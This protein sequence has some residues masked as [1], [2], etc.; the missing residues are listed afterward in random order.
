MSYP[1]GSAHGYNEGCRCTRCREANTKRARAR[2]EHV[3]TLRELINGRW[4]S[5]YTT[6][7]TLNGYGNWQCR[8][9]ACCDV[10]SKNLKRLRDER[11]EKV[12]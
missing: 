12:S 2:R 6:H 9:A 1:H 10:H 3:R 7:G 8:C 5:P 4:V 11:R